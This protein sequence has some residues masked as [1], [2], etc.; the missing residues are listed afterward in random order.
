MGLSG[1]GKSTFI[2]TFNGLEPYQKGRIEIDGTLVDHNQKGIELLRRE[3][4]MVFQQFNL[5]PHLTV[6][7]NITLGPIHLRSL[8]KS[9]A[10][11]NAMELLEKVGIAH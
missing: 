6:L 7:K 3:V 10:K 1:S 5:F 2:R 4:G 8:S 9:E 11:A